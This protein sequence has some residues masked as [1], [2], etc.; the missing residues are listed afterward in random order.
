MLT[1]SE[2]MN[3]LRLDDNDETEII[4]TDLLAAVPE[5]IYAATGLTVQEQEQDSCCNLCDTAAGFILRL[6]YYPEHAD[7][8]RL[9]RVIDGLLKSITT[10]RR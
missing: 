3:I 1:T 7:A 9:Q 4:I 8:D 6:W 5:Y 10:L 2:A